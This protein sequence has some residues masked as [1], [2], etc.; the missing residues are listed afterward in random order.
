MNYVLEFTPH[1]KDYLG[2]KQYRQS[3]ASVILLP[4]VFVFPANSSAWGKMKN[5]GKCI[6][7]ALEL[8]SGIFRVLKICI[9]KCV[10]AFL[11]THLYTLKYADDIL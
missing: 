7:H 4:Q 1:K 6:V 8:Y 5:L 9:S 2:W 3:R 10:T 11:G